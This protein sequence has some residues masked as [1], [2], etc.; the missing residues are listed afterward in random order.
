M[1]GE[2]SWNREVEAAKLLLENYGAQQ[3]NPK[4]NQL[5]PGPPQGLQIDGQEQNCLHICWNEPAINPKAVAKYQVQMYSNIGKES[6]T[7]LD[8]HKRDFSLICG[9]KEEDLSF[10]VRSV[11]INGQTSEFSHEIKSTALKRNIVHNIQLNSGIIRGASLGANLLAVTG[12][13]IGIV[14]RVLLGALL[15]GSYA[16]GVGMNYEIGKVIRETFF[17]AILGGI[18]SIVDTSLEVVVLGLIG[19]A[20]VGCFV[21]KRGHEISYAIYG[22]FNRLLFEVLGIIFG[23]TLGLGVAV[24]TDLGKLF[25]GVIVGLYIGN[26]GKHIMGVNQEL[27]RF[28]GAAIIGVLAYMGKFV[29]ALIGMVVGLVVGLSLRDILLKLSFVELIVVVLMPNKGKNIN[30]K[31]MEETFYAT[32]VPLGVTFGVVLGSGV[33]KETIVLTVMAGVLGEIIGI[34]LAMSLNSSLFE[35]LYVV[36]LLATHLEFTGSEDYLKIYFAVMGSIFGVTLGADIVL[37]HAEQEQSST[38]LQGTYLGALIGT[39]AAKDA[40]IPTEVFALAFIGGSLG[41]F[42]GGRFHLTLIGAQMAVVLCT[43]FEISG[44]ILGILSLISA[45]SVAGIGAMIGV[46]VDPVTAIEAKLILEYANICLE[47]PGMKLKILY[48]G[49]CVGGLMLLAKKMLKV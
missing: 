33:V 27:A 39:L 24:G 36:I 10:R 15:M 22:D 26:L 30:L 18:T 40:F 12:T 25:L 21:I 48:I 37:S 7:I 4:E 19:G 17:G 29:G 31:R 46:K 5:I 43:Y 16:R 28:L 20:I 2:A 45:I 6:H 1:L 47:S 42:L 32:I 3:A 13:Y 44:V 38:S 35:L 23:A 34:I 14:I 8:I 9:I 11:N 49:G 41:R